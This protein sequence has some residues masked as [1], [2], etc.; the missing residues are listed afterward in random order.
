[1]LDSEGPEFGPNRLLPLDA[2]ISVALAFRGPLTP[3]DIGLAQRRL[4]A[5]LIEMRDD[6]STEYGSCIAWGVKLSD[7]DTQL[8]N[9]HLVESI[10]SRGQT[11]LSADVN[12]INIL[13]S[14]KMFG[15][16]VDLRVND[17]SVGLEDHTPVDAKVYLL[18]GHSQAT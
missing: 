12:G 15:R 17:S 8:L 13:W 4:E 14:G 1:M 16:R 2:Q 9:K 5:L 10:G 11:D 7:E 3:E 18:G 6:K